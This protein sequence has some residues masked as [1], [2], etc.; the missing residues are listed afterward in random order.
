[1]AIFKEQPVSRKE[2]SL[3]P[4][5]LPTKNENDFSSLNAPSYEPSTRR[6]RETKESVIGADLTIQSSHLGLSFRLSLP[7]CA[8]AGAKLA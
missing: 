6:S 1:M 4:Q 2:P 3:G 7:A 5:D 8:M